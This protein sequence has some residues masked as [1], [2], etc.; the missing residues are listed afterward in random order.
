[1]RHNIGYRIVQS[2]GDMRNDREQRRGPQTVQQRVQGGGYVERM[3]NAEER[4]ADL[5]VNSQA[6]K[7]VLVSVCYLLN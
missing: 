6:Y 5:H 4:Q 3:L 7:T 1:M 2:K